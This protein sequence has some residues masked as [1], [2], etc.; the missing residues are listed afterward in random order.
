MPPTE[1]DFAPDLPS[2]LIWAPRPFPDANLLLVTGAEPALIDSGFVAHAAQTAEWVQA[3]TPSPLA[4]VV[5]TH[6]HSDHI[7]GNALLQGQGAAIAASVPDADA[8]S[9]R[10]PGCCLAEYL[11]QPVAAYTVDQ[12]L[13]DGQVV[14]LGDTDWQVI[15]TPGHTPGHLALWQPDERILATGDSMSDYDVGWVNLALDGP[16]AAK[17]ALLS[18]EVMA[19]LDPRLVIPAHGRIPSDPAAAFA[20]A[21]RR[22]SRLVD[23]LPGAVWYGIRRVFGYALMIRAGIEES[24]LEGYL[25]DRAWLQ[26]AARLLERDPEGL[27]TELVESML[28]SGAVTR[29]EGKIHASAEHTAVD[30]ATFD[31]PLP[32]E[33]D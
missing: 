2:W 10:D 16:D 23:D 31:L 18:I 24:Q 21:H 12:P 4:T 14:R 9:R 1:P 29:R 3:H 27:A 7:G 6:W 19:E 8:L 11:D 28:A 17:T 33:W 22:A 20:A 15:A 5:N 13:R 26:D 30:P 32:R 25:L